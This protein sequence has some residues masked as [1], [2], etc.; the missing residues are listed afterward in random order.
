[1]HT[2]QATSS[3]ERRKSVGSSLESKINRLIH[4]KPH[5]NRGMPRGTLFHRPTPSVLPV[6]AITK[7]MD[8]SSTA[9]R[10]RKSSVDANNKQILF[11]I[12]LQLL[13][14]VIMRIFM[15][16]NPS[17]KINGHQKTWHGGHPAQDRSG[18]CWCGDEDGYCMCTPALSVDIVLYEKRGDSYSVWAVRRK[19]TGQLGTIGG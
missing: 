13:I 15:I 3:I 17:T 11:F 10:R 16:S 19:D 18:S 6:A 14:F 2:R 12:A 5:I 9:K 7:P 1:M 4:C 8:I